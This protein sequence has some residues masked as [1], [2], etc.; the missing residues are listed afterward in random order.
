VRPSAP[1]DARDDER[2]AAARGL[3]ISLVLGV[4][5]WTVLAAVAW[6]VLR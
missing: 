1:D 5:G 4:L 2:F 3:V 6:A